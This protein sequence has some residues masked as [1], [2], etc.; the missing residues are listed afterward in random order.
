M[1][2]SDAES[3][4][5]K[6]PTNP[7]NPFSIAARSAVSS[8]PADR[9][10]HKGTRR[11]IMSPKRLKKR[12]S[13]QAATSQASN[14][15]T[16]L[17][18]VPIDASETSDQDDQEGEEDGEE[19]F[20]QNSQTPGPESS[21]SQASTSFKRPRAKTSGIYEN[22]NLRDHRFYCNHCS[23]SFAISGGTG[24]VARH[25]KKAHSIDS[26]HNSIAE[27]RIREGTAI[28]I[29]ILRDAEIN[30]KAEEQRRKDLIDINLDRATLE[31]LYL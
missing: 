7:T 20:S 11:G 26:S 21:V 10:R 6:A 29:A 23:K 5:S 15:H 12:S 3:E 19:E 8:I 31:Y 9:T 28:D 22:V 17:A 4:L 14:N 30:I 27:K 2:S 16:A 1:T 13:T 24:S 18:T 25:L